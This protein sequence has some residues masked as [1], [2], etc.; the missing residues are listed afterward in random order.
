MN[1]FQ[2]ASKAKLRFETNAGTLTTEDLWD[3]PLSDESKTEDL[4]RI[5]KRLNKLVK[6]DTEEDFVS[7]VS[8]SNTID[9]LRF[10]IVKE[11]IDIRIEELDKK[12]SEEAKRSRIQ[13]IKAKLAAAEDKELDEKTPEE[14]KAMLAEI[15]KE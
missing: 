6:S 12:N 13:R 2:K 5:A 3:L 1:N 10:D 9:K 15:E 8:K 7:I 11:V 14:L 4:N